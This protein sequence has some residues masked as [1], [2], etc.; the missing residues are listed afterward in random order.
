MDKEKE[1]RLN[2]RT[3]EE[4]KTE[5]KVRAIKKKMSMGEYLKY[6]LMLDINKDEREELK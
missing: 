1:I 3:T 2:V 5:F 6:L 4:L